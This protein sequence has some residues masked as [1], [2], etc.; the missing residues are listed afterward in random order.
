MQPTPYLLLEYDVLWLLRQ[1]S[2]A[3]N[4]GTAYR[5]LHSVRWGERRA[6]RGVRVKGI[7]S[8]NVTAKL[9]YRASRACLPNRLRGAADKFDRVDR[10]V[11]IRG[12][13]PCQK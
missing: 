7:H 2:C 10:S 13:F 3:P 12:C 1:D 4:V 9:N 5:S 8:V 11:L 6:I